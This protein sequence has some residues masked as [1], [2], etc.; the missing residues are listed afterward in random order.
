MLALSKA[1]LTEHIFKKKKKLKQ[2]IYSRA[3]GA[4]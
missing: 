3:E 1:N 2:N 4:V